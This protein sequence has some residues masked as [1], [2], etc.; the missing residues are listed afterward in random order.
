L[1][2]RGHC[3]EISG[4]RQHALADYTAVLKLEGTPKEQVAYALVNRGVAKARLGDTQGALADYTAVVVLKGAPKERVARA[5]F[6]RGVAK[7][8]LGDT[9][10]ELADYT[11]VVA[12]EGAPKK[13][14]ALAL[15]NRGFAKVKLGDNE[16][17]LAEYTA[18]VTLEGAPKEE[19][20]RALIC[21]AF[22]NQALCQ[23][24]S[25]IADWTTF[26]ELGASFEGGVNAAAEILFSLS[27]PD[28]ATN[29]ANNALDHLARHLATKPSDQRVLALTGF[30]ARLA[31]PAMRQGWLH[32]ARRLLGAQPPETR[33]AL[34]FLEPVC[35]VL[36]GGEKSLLDPLPPEQRE[37]ALK[38]L[39]RFDAGKNPLVAP[40]TAVA[41]SPQPGLKKNQPQAAK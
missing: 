28:G 32:A 11:A 10:G 1:L 20:A 13:E 41:D 24:A 29:E 2:E 16:G 5:L 25:A 17:A 31:S 4:D 26:L 38:V 8:E 12:L 7:G 15:V 40:P 33:Q 6:N 36:E 19:M 30:L 35:T 34:S 22:T 27:W 3:F 14:V 9:R 39:A 37:F 18:V 23:K 21:R